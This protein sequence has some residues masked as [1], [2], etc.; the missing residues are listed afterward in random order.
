MENSN[1][2]TALTPGQKAALTRAQ[3]QGKT[4]R[5]ASP[6]KAERAEGIG[7]ALIVT[8]SDKKLSVTF[9]ATKRGQETSRFDLPEQEASFP[10]A[11]ITAWC[12]EGKLVGFRD[13]PRQRLGYGS[14]ARPR[15]AGP[16]EA[17][18]VQSSSM[19][20]KAKALPALR[21]RFSHSRTIRG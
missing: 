4:P 11:G 21:K 20:R 9:Q 19:R 8:E 18:A 5:P 14:T 10:L 6:A 3:N 15:S 16:H 13:V 17:G 12:S 1:A 7:L 2:V